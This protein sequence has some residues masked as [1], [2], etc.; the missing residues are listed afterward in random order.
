MLMGHLP[1][2]IYHEVYYL[3]YKDIQVGIH[4]RG[5]TVGL[6]EGAISYDRGTLALEGFQ[7]GIHTVFR[8]RQVC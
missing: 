3:L 1:R 5:P 7:A 2:V 6:G 8:Y 4:T